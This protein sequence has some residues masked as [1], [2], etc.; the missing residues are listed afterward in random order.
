[1]IHVTIYRSGMPSPFVLARSAPAPRQK[2]T[3]SILAVLAFALSLS[4]ESA[5]GQDYP[6][7]PVTIV[8]PYV[9]G[10]PTDVLAR[11]LGAALSPAL[12]QQIIVENYGGA[13]GTIGTA[14]VARAQPDGYTMLLMHIGIATAPALYRKL[15]YDTVNDFEPIG[16]VADVPM[17]LIARP[18]FPAAGFREFLDYIKAHRQSLS[19]AH[20]GVGS[21]SHLCGLMFMSVIATDL[22]TV[23]YKGN[24]PAMNDLLGGQVDLMCDQTTNTTEQIKAAKVKAYGATSLTRIPSLP[25]LPTLDEQGLKGF[26]VIAW[27]GLWVPKGTPKPI[28]DKIHSALRTAVQDQGFNARMHELGALPASLQQ[29]TPEALRTFLKSEIDRW[30]PV[31]KAAGVYAD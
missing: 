22:T 1:V 14:R 13:G 5:L 31:I 4:T 20:A 15:P 18:T 7:R 3:R 30:R 29:A 12:K 8:V 10:G 9:A 6:V 27:Y 2:R 25:E 24:A 11:N 17:A 16:R 21:S 23:P 19:L 28:I 26:E